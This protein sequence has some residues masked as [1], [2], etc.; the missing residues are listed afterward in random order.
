[1]G[2]FAEAVKTDK[3]LQLQVVAA[4]KKVAESNGHSLDEKSYTAQAKASSGC[5]YYCAT[6]CYCTD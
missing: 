1:M 4:I 5:E 2:N 6:L 3:G